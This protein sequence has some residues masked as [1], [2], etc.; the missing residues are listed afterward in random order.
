MTVTANL[1]SHLKSLEA[2]AIEIMRVS[3]GIPRPRAA[4]FYR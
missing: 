4:I 3:S 2:E 1:K